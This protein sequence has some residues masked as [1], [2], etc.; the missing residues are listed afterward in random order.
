MRN[1]GGCVIDMCKTD[2]VGWKGVQ[3]KPK[4]G[5]KGCSISICEVRNAVA[6]KQGGFPCPGLVP[7]YQRLPRL[8]FR[9]LKVKWKPVQRRKIKLPKG[10]ETRSRETWG[11]ELGVSDWQKRK[12]RGP[13]NQFPRRRKTYPMEAK[14]KTYPMEAKWFLISNGEIKDLQG[15]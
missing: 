14:A 2:L 11:E 4:S 6:G 8:A 15:E 12:L 13:V 9:A 1:Q 5:R 10:L 7:T 3:Y